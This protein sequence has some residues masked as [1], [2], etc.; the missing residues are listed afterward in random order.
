MLV[1]DLI[2]DVRTASLASGA[3]NQTHSIKLWVKAE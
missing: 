1:T 3:T 2:G